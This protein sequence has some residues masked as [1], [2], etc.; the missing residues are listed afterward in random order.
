MPFNEEFAA[1]ALHRIS[2]FI[3]VFSALGAA[4]FWITLGWKAGGSFILGALIAVI[5]FQ[6]L[7]SS[8]QKVITALVA[9]TAER[10]RIWHKLLLRYLLLAAVVYVIF[11]GYSLHIPAFLTGL[12]LPVLAC[13]CEAIYEAFVAFRHAE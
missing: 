8:V 11:R 1:H 4:A 12:L 3:L 7:Q 5:N 2:R 9:G 10:P 13:M 6:W